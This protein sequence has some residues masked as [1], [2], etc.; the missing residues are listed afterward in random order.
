MNEVLNLYNTGIKYWNRNDIDNA[1]IYMDK[2][3]KFFEQLDTY[4]KKNLV[5]FY[6][7]INQP[8]KYVK[9]LKHM[10]YKKE[11]ILETIHS[12]LELG[13]E[14]LTESDLFFIERI[15]LIKS[16]VRINFLLA[17]VYINKGLILRAYERATNTLDYV[18]YSINNEHTNEEFYYKLL[19]MVVKMEYEFDNFTQARFQLKKLINTPIHKTIKYHEHIIYWSCILGTIDGM[20]VNNDWYEPL[21]NIEDKEVEILV[22]TWVNI[23]AQKLSLSQYN[24]FKN[25]FSI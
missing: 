23:Y 18:E 21:H 17:D 11:D 1:T 19:I 10:L 9:I 3:L 24:I 4:D 2:T 25:I 14:Q 15:H 20:L 5:K 22:N 16:D 12:L 13:K 7:Y 6:I 8:E